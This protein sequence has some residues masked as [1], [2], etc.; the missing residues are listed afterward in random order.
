VTI[1]KLEDQRITRAY[2]RRYDDTGQTKAYVEWADG[3]RT[4]GNGD[5]LGVHMQALFD[6]ARRHGLTITREDW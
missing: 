1:R 2:V 3:S 5:R 4:E 6:R